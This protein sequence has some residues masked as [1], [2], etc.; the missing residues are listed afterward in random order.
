VAKVNGI[1]LGY[2]VSGQGAPMILLH[3]AFGSG[4]MFGAN[5]ELLARRRR[6]I[7]V[8]LASHGRSPTADRP[9]RYERMADDVAA[10]IEHLGLGRVAIMGYS[11]GGAVALR[12]GIQ[13]PSLVER[14][15]LLSTVYKRDGWYP[16]TAAQMDAMGPE[17]ADH[18]R[19]T[20]LYHVYE[21][22]APHVDGWPALVRQV[23][24]IVKLDYDWAAEV[25]GLPMRVMLI[26]GD[27]DG[28]PPSHAAEFFALLGGGQQDGGWD[29]SGMTHHRLAIL[30]GA[31]HNDI[32]NLS[33]L[34]ATVTPF[35]DG[36]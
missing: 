23:S 15:V 22:V 24:E 35:L 5:I 33:A 32:P 16:E 7:A 2:Q 6:V 10:L 1:E 30:P 20:P 4:E 25:R 12:T 29:R 31:T 17:T 34:T 9:M 36:A 26:V 28:L 3:G 8:D 11:L 14:L 18:L 19:Q 27:A 21:Q 13:H